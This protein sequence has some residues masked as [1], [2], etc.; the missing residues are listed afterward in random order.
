MDSFQSVLGDA[1]GGALCSVLSTYGSAAPLL[2]AISLIEPTPIGEAV[3]VSAGL[4]GL[5]ATVGCSW[6]TNGQGPPEDKPFE[7]CRK[8]EGGTITGRV[9]SGTP[10]NIIITDFLIFSGA[11]EVYRF[12]LAGQNVQGKWI[13]EY[14]ILQ[15]QGTGN[16]PAVKSGQAFLSRNDYN[17]YTYTTGSATCVEYSTG[18]QPQPP[19]Y[20]HT[21]PASGCEI[22][23]DFLGWGLR[24]SGNVSGIWEMAP[25]LPASRSSGGVIG[26]CNFAPTIYVDGGGG[27]A[28]GGGGY[29]FPVPDP[30]PPDGDEPWWAPLARGAVQGAAAAGTQAVLDKLFETPYPGGTYQLNGVCERDP[31]G[32][33]MDVTRATTFPPAAGIDAVLHRLDALAEMFQF[34]KELRQPTCNV[35]P[36][37]T[38][39]WVTVNFQSEEA[40]PGGERPLRKQFR[41]RDQTSSPLETHLAH[42]ESFEWDAGPVIV[43]SKNLSWGEPKVWAASIEEGKRV[44]RH[45]AQVAGVDLDDPKH[46][47]IVSGSRDPRYGR[48]GRMKLDTR[49]GK[50][51]RVTSRPGPSGLP[52]GFGPD[53]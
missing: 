7:G 46:E 34:D 32:D 16:P 10:D 35:K 27:G 52:Y 1:A 48:T 18:T 15:D 8:A 3:A 9:G 20:T 38:G 50:F 17:L 2:T 6:D 28:G 31:N 44:I 43:V 36:A 53:S 45:A 29:S 41:Y 4:A 26:G 39:D 49:R 5:A 11:I 22:N 42:W 30:L 33:P 24:E 21:D 40:S 37:L 19:T 51:L 23:V 13:Y 12:A 14:E 47:W 25:N